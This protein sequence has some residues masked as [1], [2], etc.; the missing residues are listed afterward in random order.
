CRRERAS[1]LKQFPGGFEEMKVSTKVGSLYRFLKVIKLPWDGDEHRQFF[2]QAQHVDFYQKD[3]TGLADELPPGTASF[4]AAVTKV[5]YSIVALLTAMRRSCE[6]VFVATPAEDVSRDGEALRNELE[7]QGYVVRPEGGLDQL[8]ADEAIQKEVEPSQLSVHLLGPSYDPFA[9]RQFRV[10]RA[11][12]KRVVCWLAKDAENKAEPK[13]REFLGSLAGSGSNGTSGV[14]LLTGPVRSMIADILQLLTANGGH[15]LTRPGSPGTAAS[16]YLVCDRSAPEDYGFAESL[17]SD[18]A[19]KEGI[20]VFLPAAAHGGPR[21]EIETHLSRLRNC[22]GVLLY[23]S[24]APVEWLRENFQQVLFAEQLVKRPPMRS[25]AYL[26]DDPSLLAG[27][28]NVIVRT[29]R[30]SLDDLE[31]FLAPLRR[32]AN[33][34]N[35]GGFDARG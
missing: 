17:R 27:V 8:F 7:A 10:S 29:P 31:T 12:E 15:S 9:E 21:D 11:M 35:L 28:G 4:D 23:R 13:Q 32:I 6:T 2:G 3:A 5:A 22:D 18:I 34:A 14:T 1:F 19:R 16:M 26:L 25:K 24:T 20:D 33:Q 30:F